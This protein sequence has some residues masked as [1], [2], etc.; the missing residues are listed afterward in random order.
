MSPPLHNSQSVRCM[1]CRTTVVRYILILANFWCAEF[2]TYFRLLLQSEETLEYCLPR[3][4]VP[5]TTCNPLPTNN[6]EKLSNHMNNGRIYE[7]RSKYMLHT[8][9]KN[10]TKRCTRKRG[11]NRAISPVLQTCTASSSKN[12]LLLVPFG[13]KLGAHSTTAGA[14]SA[15][16]TKR[17]T[18]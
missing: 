18:D 6:P 15:F 9:G 8:R 13:E 5:E 12:L 1:P 10:R 7:P 3:Y 11:E 17:P 2:F 4:N 16:A 14:C